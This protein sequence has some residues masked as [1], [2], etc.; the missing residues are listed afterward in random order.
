M[1]NI[2]ALR[3]LIK[4][5][6]RAK[7]FLIVL[8]IMVL[9]VYLLDGWL[10]KF[11]FVCTFLQLGYFIFIVFP[12]Y[13]YLK[14]IKNVRTRYAILKVMALYKEAFSYGSW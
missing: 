12:I 6:R 5:A 1:N 3:Q 13:V 4:D 11:V 7:W 8:N 2:F 14:Y 9:V 10:N